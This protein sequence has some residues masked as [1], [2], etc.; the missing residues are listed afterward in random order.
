MFDFLMKGH[1]GT[2]GKFVR[3]F[4]NPIMA[5][6][7]NTARRLSRRIR[8][9]ILRRLKSEVAKDLPEKIE[10]DEFDEVGR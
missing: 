1:L 5:G 7:D 6:D 10:M 2:L 4:E 3:V 8:P 9:F